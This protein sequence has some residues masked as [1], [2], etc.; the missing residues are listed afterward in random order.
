LLTHGETN[1][2]WQKHN[3]G[4]GKNGIVF[5]SIGLKIEENFS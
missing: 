1:K 5:R 4:E 3:L 2:L